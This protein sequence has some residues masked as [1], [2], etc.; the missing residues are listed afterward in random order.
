MHGLIVNQRIPEEV[1]A[2]SIRD[3]IALE[4]SRVCQQR[5]ERPHMYHD[6][7]VAVYN[8]KSLGCQVH[9]AAARGRR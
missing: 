5:K 6:L 9:W 8:I 3:N 7:F 4:I 1:N 2:H